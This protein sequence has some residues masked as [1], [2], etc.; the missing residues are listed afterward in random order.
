[1]LVT[2]QLTGHS[3]VCALD[4]W[5]EMHST[6]FTL[7]CP[8]D[9]PKWFIK[10]S[11]FISFSSGLLFLSTLIYSTLSN[12]RSSCSK[13]YSQLI[14]LCSFVDFSYIL[15]SYLCQQVRV[16]EFEIYSFINFSKWKFKVNVSYYWNWMDRL[17][18]L[19]IMLKSW[20]LRGFWVCKLLCAQLWYYIILSAICL[21]LSK[22]L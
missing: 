8:M 9:S 1:M 4:L 21:L 22:F 5:I 7:N 17:Q 13:H 3:I 2:V 19:I 15:S 6:V 20:D 16:A 12:K 10:L 18:V 14:L 11:Y